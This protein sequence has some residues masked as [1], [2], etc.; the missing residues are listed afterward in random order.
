M[1]W[2]R[3]VLVVLVSDSELGRFLWRLDSSCSVCDAERC[4]IGVSLGEIETV[5]LVV[6]TVVDAAVI[7]R[8]CDC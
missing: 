1:S 8:N 5:G 3:G 6:A 7:E 2:R 4:G